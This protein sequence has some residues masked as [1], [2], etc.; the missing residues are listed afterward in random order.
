MPLLRPAFDLGGHLKGENGESSGHRWT[1]TH[2]K[3]RMGGMIGFLK[4]L[5]E[6]QSRNIASEPRNWISVACDE[7]M[8]TVFSDD[9]HPI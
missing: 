4:D 6:H 3:E 8:K 9:V 1:S 2:E 5:E 7:M